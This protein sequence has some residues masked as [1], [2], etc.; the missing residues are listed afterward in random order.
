MCGSSSKP[1][2]PPPPPAPPPVNPVQA[3]NVLQRADGTKRSDSSAS[4][5]MRG[6]NSLR[7][8]RSAV[9]LGGGGGNGLNIP[10]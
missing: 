3:P 2:P 10:S 9:T 1:A 8:D 6:R 5:A 7:I 4:T